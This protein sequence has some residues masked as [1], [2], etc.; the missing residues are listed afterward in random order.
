MSWLIGIIRRWILWWWAR[1]DEAAEFSFPQ[2]L[3]TAK[4]VLV[5][6]PPSIEAMRDS[7]VFLSRLPR[8][9]PKARVTLLYPPNSI[10]ARFYNPHGY[11]CVVPESKNVRLFGIPTRKLI[12]KVVEKPFDVVISLNRD[13]SIFY[14]VMTI[15]SKAPLRIGLPDGMGKPFVNVEL[16]HGRDDADIKSEFILFIEMIRKLAAPP[17]VGPTPPPNPPRVR[18]SVRI[19]D[20][21]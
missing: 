18:D 21:S 5:L 8:A 7:E 4:R 11:T 9:L 17:P 19:R 3:R 16:R 1:K 13:E 20:G 2:A 10:V 15:A 12:N 14:G 6:M